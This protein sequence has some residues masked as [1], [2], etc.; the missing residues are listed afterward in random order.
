MKN[1][2]KRSSIFL[3]LF[4]TLMVTGTTLLFFIHISISKYHLI[5]FFLLTTIIYYFINKNKLIKKDFYLTIGISII[6]IITSKISFRK[7]FIIYN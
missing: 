4:L 2:L 1:V 5:S 6:V 3:L 7:F